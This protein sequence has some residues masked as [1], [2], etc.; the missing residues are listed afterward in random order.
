MGATTHGSAGSMVVHSRWM[1]GVGM[2]ET[3]GLRDQC[4]CGKR[5]V[6]ERSAATGGRVSSAMLRD[7]RRKAG[8]QAMRKTESQAIERIAAG[9]K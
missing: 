2:D 7:E 1:G 4:R 3:G 9:R 6:P 5:S 8:G